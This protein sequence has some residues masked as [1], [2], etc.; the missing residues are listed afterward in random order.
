MISININIITYHQLIHN[1]NNNKKK[2][3]KLK[4]K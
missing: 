2:R 1:N 3:Q 4:L